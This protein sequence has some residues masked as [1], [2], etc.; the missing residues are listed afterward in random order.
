MSDI[1]R[2]FPKNPILTPADIYPSSDGMKVECLL[3]PGVFR[4]DG[5]TWL[6]VRVAERPKQKP[7]KTSLPIFNDAGVPQILE[8]NNS[9]DKLDISDPR[10]LRYDGV[11]FLTTL[12]HLRL[13][14]STDEIHFFESRTHS[15]LFG[16]GLLERYGIEDCRVAQIGER[17]YLT[18][19]QVSSNGVGVGLRS[20][21]DWKNILTHGM[22]FPPHNK[23][24]AIFDQ[25]INGKYYALHRPS[26]PELGGNY[27]W[28]AESPD[29]IHWGNHRCIAHTRPDSWDS[30]RVGAGAAPI[31]TAEGWLEIYHGADAKHRYCLGALLLDLREPWKVLARSRNPIMEPIARYEQNGFFGNVIFTNGHI[32]N[33]DVITMYYGAS[34][35]VICGAHFSINEILAL[36]KHA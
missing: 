8:F 2:R 34:D 17:Y 1:A 32:V 14:S 21:S 3:N 26:S 11:D 13:M 18:Y 22:I 10:V 23:D 31:R 29:L 25:Q 12:S 36:L 7:G 35:S 19:T 4:F 30:Q 27:I 20:T 6:L 15:L 33:G 24:C 9:D 16:Q 28:L 5:K